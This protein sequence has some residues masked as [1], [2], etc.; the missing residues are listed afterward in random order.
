MKVFMGGT[1]IM[2]TLAP[3]VQPAHTVSTFKAISIPHTLMAAIPNVNIGGMSHTL[4]ELGQQILLGAS[5]VVVVVCGIMIAVGL[6]KEGWKRV[7]S[8]IQG[9]GV[10]LVGPTV[11]VI[12]AGLFSGFAKMLT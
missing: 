11:V 2:D 9:L 1:Q 7:V 4:V 12:V 6:K 5:G 10:G 3:I 8:I